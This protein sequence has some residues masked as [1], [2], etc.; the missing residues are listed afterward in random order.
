MAIT[1]RFT[2]RLTGD[3]ADESLRLNDLITQLD[4]VKRALNELDK[5][6]T[7]KS[8]TTLYYRVVGL[9]MRSP[10]E[11]VIEAVS[12]AKTKAGTPAKS[13]HGSVV[14]KRLQHDIEQVGRGKRPAHADIELLET[15][16]DLS[17][18]DTHV[19]RFEIETGRVKVEVPQSIAAK[20]DTILGPDQV[21]FGSLVGSLEVIDI[22]NKRNNFRIFPAV[23]RSSIKCHFPTALLPDALAG[24]N[25]FVRISG[26]LHF[27]SSEKFP[28]YMAVTKIEL[29]PDRPADVSLKS[30]RGMAKN[31]FGSL[32]S[33]DYV[34]K[35]R[36]GDW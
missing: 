9:S 12:K 10:A 8:N 29:L 28:H 6:V 30:I 27:K 14:V 36:D 23:G 17:P 2:I 3:E 11:V 21:E 35:V 22:H 31:A 18:R 15:Y 25:H 4:A 1:N 32:S 13:K 20:V 7:G 5:R 26:E 33:T 24:I 16:K 19:T 34:N